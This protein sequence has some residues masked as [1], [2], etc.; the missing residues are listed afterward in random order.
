MEVAKIYILPRNEN[1]SP[2]GRLRTH[3]SRRPA[4]ISVPAEGRAGEF[5]NR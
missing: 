1:K 4:Q 2:G 3:P 5:F